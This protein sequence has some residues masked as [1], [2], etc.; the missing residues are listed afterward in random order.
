MNKVLDMR[1]PVASS[2]VRTF[3]SATVIVVILALFV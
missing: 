2:G 1:T 3:W